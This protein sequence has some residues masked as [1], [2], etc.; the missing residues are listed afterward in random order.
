M[1]T[2]IYAYTLLGINTAE[3]TGEI[4]SIHKNT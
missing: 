3:Y 4:H 1:K 2:Q